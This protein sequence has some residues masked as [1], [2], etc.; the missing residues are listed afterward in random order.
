MDIEE[1]KASILSTFNSIFDKALLLAEEVVYRCYKDKSKNYLSQ[2]GN[3]KQLFGCVDDVWGTY[4]LVED[5][6]K[7][8]KF[9]K[10]EGLADIFYSR[11]ED[12]DET[13]NYKFLVLESVV[14]VFGRTVRWSFNCGY[15]KSNK[16]VYFKH[17][18]LERAANN[19][20]KLIQFAS[21]MSRDEFDSYIPFLLKEFNLT[22]KHLIPS[23]SRPQNV[24]KEEVKKHPKEKLGV[25]VEIVNQ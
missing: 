1:T 18:K 21:T 10:E 22:L 9:A 8:C 25:K 7:L 6:M 20:V 23:N 4:K 3:K 5:Y 15:L 13:F 16:E 24:E 12:K 14:R 2:E 19:Y 17:L 11:K